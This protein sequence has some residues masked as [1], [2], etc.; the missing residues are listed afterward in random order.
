MSRSRLVVAIVAVSVFALPA[1]AQ[2]TSDSRAVRI[3]VPSSPGGGADV[4]A[5]MIADHAGRAHGRTFVVENRPGGGNTI[6]TEAVARAAPDGA[7][8]LI[9]TPEFVINPHVRTLSY[10]PLTSFEPICYLARSPQL[11]VVEANAPYRTLD[12]FLQ[13]ARANPGKLT[14]ASAG[15]ASSPHVAIE[16][17]RREGKVDLTYVPFQGSGPAINALLGQHVNAV[18]ASFPNVIGAIQS[19]KL[20]AIATT[21][22]TRIGDLPDVHT[23]AESGYSNFDFDLWFGAAAPAGTSRAAIGQLAT[24]FKQTLADREIL[25]KLKAQGFFAVGS[26]EADYAAFT[27]RQFDAYGQ[28]IKDAGLSVK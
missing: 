12:E 7:T 21:A 15:P 24:L 8:I 13:A 14:I 11:I 6:G 10:D 20:R 1:G 5:R 28:A 19:G 22:A 23:V 3:V 18:V 27:R 25:S 26:C 4:L 9:T 16:R 2:T 17:I